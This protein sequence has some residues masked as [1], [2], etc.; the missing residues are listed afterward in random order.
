MAAL[1]AIVS[2]ALAKLVLA[3][4]WLS[5]LPDVPHD[6]EDIRI[7][8]FERGIGGPFLNWDLLT[9]LGLLT[10]AGLILIIYLM[11]LWRNEAQSPIHRFERN[12]FFPVNWGSVAENTCRYRYCR[13]FSW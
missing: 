8:S 7:K 1:T 12:L 4:V 11:A 6:S 3:T 9:V 5:Q 10:L 13:S 2:E